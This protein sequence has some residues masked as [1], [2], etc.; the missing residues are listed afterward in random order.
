MGSNESHRAISRKDEEGKCT[1]SLCARRIKVTSFYLL[2]VGAKYNSRTYGR[3][4]KEKRRANESPPR[5]S[6]AS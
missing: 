2:L 1:K 4:D 3:G 6:E 5:I